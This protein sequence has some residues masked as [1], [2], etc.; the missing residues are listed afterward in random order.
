MALVDLPLV[1]IDGAVPSATRAR[2]AQATRAAL[3]GM[4]TAGID[5]PQVIEGSLGRSA[6]ILGAAGLPLAHFFQPDGAL[7]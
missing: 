4:P 1:V 2:L 3:E 5:R 7:D 6:R